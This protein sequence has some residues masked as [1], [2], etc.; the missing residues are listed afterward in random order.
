MRGQGWWK[1]HA[2]LSNGALL[3]PNGGDR[4]SKAKGY[5]RRAKVKSV[6]VAGGSH[7]RLLK[8]VFEFPASQ[9]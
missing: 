3:V 6:E 9:R 8:P 5:P 4:R 1:A 2:C 7:A